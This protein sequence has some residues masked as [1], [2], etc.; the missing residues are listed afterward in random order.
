MERIWHPEPE[1]FIV[2]FK[3]FSK[4]TCT[5]PDTSSR[6]LNEKTIPDL[7]CGEQF[8]HSQNLY[9]VRVIQ[10]CNFLIICIPVL[11]RGSCI[12]TFLR[13]CRPF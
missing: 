7:P 9:F 5:A 12:S 6:F 2:Y 13:I 3:A 8:M 1:D 11:C 4:T 10:T